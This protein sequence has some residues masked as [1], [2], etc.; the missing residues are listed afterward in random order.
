MSKLSERVLEGARDALAFAKG[1]VA[2]SR[3]HV[4]A[5][6]HVEDGNF[7]ISFPDF[8]G[9]VTA[10]AS[11]DEAIARGASLLVFHIRGMIADGDW[12]PA[13]RPIEHLREDAEG[14]EVVMVTADL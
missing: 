12:P 13:K 8:P 1:D 2:G 4:P 9:C 5:L 10:G 14:A 11:K 7:G 3:M 6:I